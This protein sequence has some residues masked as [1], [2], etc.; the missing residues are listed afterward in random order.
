[1]P[2]IQMHIFIPYISAVHPWELHIGWSPQTVV[3]SCMHQRCPAPIWCNLL[4]KHTCVYV[5]LWSLIPPWKFQCTLLKF[6]SFYAEAACLLPSSSRISL[7]YNSTKQF[8]LEVAVAICQASIDSIFGVR[9]TEN[10]TLHCMSVVVLNELSFHEQHQ[11]DCC[12]V[13]MLT[14]SEATFELVLYYWWWTTIIFIRIREHVLNYH[15]RRQSR[16]VWMY[17][18][19]TSCVWTCRTCCRGM[20]DQPKLYMLSYL[21]PS[22]SSESQLDVVIGV[23]QYIVKYSNLVWSI[24]SIKVLYNLQ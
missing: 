4:L 12:V 13:K 11:E 14:W 20:Q 16:E 24:D 3:V 2:L 22:S 15:I 1:M 7:M 6:C 5:Q 21:R 9:T 8:K 19:V 17:G 23:R 10:H 18:A